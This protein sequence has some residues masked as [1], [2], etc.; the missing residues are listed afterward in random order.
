MKLSVIIVAYNSTKVLLDCLKSIQCYNDI[1]QNLEVIIVDN[2]KDSDLNQS[3]F[4]DYNYVVT[5]VRSNDNRGFGAGN[6][7]GA[8]KST[9]DILFFLN[10]DTILT[11]PIFGDIINKIQKNKK[12][13]YGFSLVDVNYKENNSYAFMYDSFFI[14]RILSIIQKL[15]LRN[16]L[17]KPLINRYIWPWGAAFAMS[18][19]V[20]V[21]AGMFDE[22]I[23]LCN[24][25]QDLVKRVPSRYIYLSD[26]RIIHLEGHGTTVSENRWYEYF[27]SRDYYFRKYKIS[28]VNVYLWDSYTSIVAFFSSL[29]RDNK[30][31]QNYYMAYRK[32]KKDNEH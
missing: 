12:L 15:K 7:I 8:L 13:I 29:Y 2:Y 23:F 27:R 1:G 11:E 18:K 14:Y 6:N 20:F 4:K 5:Y 24:E 22:N 31:L 19:E 25:E 16:L 26:K 32:Y 10:P 17:N 3:M 21:E 30:S 9:S 28:K